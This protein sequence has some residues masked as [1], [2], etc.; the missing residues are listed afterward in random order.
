MI[1]DEAVEAGYAALNYLAIGRDEI[2]VILEAAAPHM[3]QAA[4]AEAWDEGIEAGVDG[5]VPECDYA[6]NPYR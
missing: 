3:G 1:P 2:R 4:K 6:R 5:S